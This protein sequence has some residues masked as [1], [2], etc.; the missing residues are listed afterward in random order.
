MKRLFNVG[1]WI[2]IAFCVLIL[3]YVLGP[4]PALPTFA[5]K[6]PEIKGTPA[7]IAQ[8]IADREA[9]TLNLKPDNEAQVI[10][11]DQTNKDVTDFCVVYLHGF[12]ASYKEGMPNA[13]NIAKYYKANLICNRMPG[14]GIAN[15]DAFLQVTPE[16]MWASAQEALAIG[17]KLGKRIIVVGTSTGAAL[18]LLLASKYPEKITAVVAYSPLISFY[19][20][21]LWLLN[22][23]WG[24]QIGA[25]VN[26]G[27]PYIKEG[28]PPQT[29]NY[30]TSE[31][32]IEGA[33]ALASLI[34]TTMHYKT[35]E[36]VNVPVFVGAYYKDEEHQ[37]KVVSVTA[38][39]RMFGLLGT[40]VGK[41]KL[42]LFPEA[43]HHVI[44]SDLRAR[45]VGKVTT[46]TIE[47]LET[48]L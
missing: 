7:E 31:Y 34:A 20:N 16:N 4:T 47:F 19:R 3:I 9:K 36:K 26:G 18:A 13:L 40:A 45:N 33:I 21:A 32:R 35:F 46:T 41:K 43:G 30:W 12:F 6:M 44:G 10:W 37:D 22:K 42:V 15:K 29:R 2:G 28:Y 48:V 24:R 11:A 14:H 1:K 27:S 25:L 17:Q 38:I 23:P 8:N 39:K 5:E